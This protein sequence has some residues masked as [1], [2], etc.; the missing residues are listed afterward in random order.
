MFSIL[1]D[2]VFWRKKIWLYFVSLVAHIK[3]SILIKDR[4]I[5]TRVMDNLCFL[6]VFC[7]KK[8]KLSMVLSN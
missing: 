3:M 8:E 5:T 1:F 6:V 2:V 7:L 4:V